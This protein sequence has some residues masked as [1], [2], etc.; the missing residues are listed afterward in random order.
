MSR[1]AFTFV[2]YKKAV[3]ER[4]EVPKLREAEQE[5]REVLKNLSDEDIDY[6]LHLFENHIY[7]GEVLRKR[8]EKLNKAEEFI[9]SIKEIFETFK[10]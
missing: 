9:N 1:L 2:K 7:T 8:T 6:L 4:A 3:L 10:L 5:I